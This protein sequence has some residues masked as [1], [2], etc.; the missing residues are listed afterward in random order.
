MSGGSETP[1]TRVYYFEEVPSY[2]HCHSLSVTYTVPRHDKSV[3]LGERGT[4]YWPNHCPNE[5]SKLVPPWNVQI[6]HL[7]MPPTSTSRN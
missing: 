7:S 5:M 3:G 6:E 2:G 4:N 1:A